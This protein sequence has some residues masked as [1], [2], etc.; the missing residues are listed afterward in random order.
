MPGSGAGVL[1]VE[2]LE[3]AEA[4]GARIYAEILGGE[5][6]CG[7]QRGGG[8]MTAPNPEGV[9]RC[10]RQAILTAGIRP[11]EIEVINGHLTATMADPLEVA[12]WLRALEREPEQFPADQLHQVADRPWPGRRGRHRARGVGAAAQPRLHPR[13]VELRGPAPGSRA[14]SRPAWCTRPAPSQAKILAKA[15]FGF[16]DVNGCLIFKKWDNV[17]ITVHL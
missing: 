11:D 12:N 13:F 15:S 8:S 14:R 7:G 2:S 16:G 3:S 1:M 17:R 4:R 6:N 5:V 10:M 9:V